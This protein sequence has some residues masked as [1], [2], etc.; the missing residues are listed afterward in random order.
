[1]HASL[2]RA[3]A[4]MA[5]GPSGAPMLTGA[6]GAARG[7]AACRPELSPTHNPDL[8]ASR[9]GKNDEQHGQEPEKGSASRPLGRGFEAWETARNGGS[10]GCFRIP[11]TW[12]CCMGGVWPVLP[13]GLAMHGLLTAGDCAAPWHDRTGAAVPHHSGWAGGRAAARWQRWFWD[14]QHDKCYRETRAWILM[15]T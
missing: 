6:N 9:M 12:H 1:M 5:L 7:P 15:L 3:G 8:L 4:G 14:S 10:G 11:I 2:A 13:S